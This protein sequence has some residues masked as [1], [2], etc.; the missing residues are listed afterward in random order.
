M[1]EGVWFEDPRI[2]SLLYADDVVLTLA[3]LWHFAA[4][5][6]PTGIG[7]STQGLRPCWIKVDGSLQVERVLAQNCSGK[8][9]VPYLWIWKDSEWL[10]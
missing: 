2:L 9:G 3:A 4:V 8:E 6:K 5:C 7:V 10:K 1:K